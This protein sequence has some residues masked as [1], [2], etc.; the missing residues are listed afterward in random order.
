M[1]WLGI[2]FI[3]L[4]VGLVIGEWYTRSGLL[5]TAGL[6]SLIFGL[7]IFFT[8]GAIFLRINW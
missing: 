3:F 1:V 2:I 4:A 7:V 6:V 5:V 8:Q